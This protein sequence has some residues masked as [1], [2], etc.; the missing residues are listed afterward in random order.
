MLPMVVME[1]SG[2]MAKAAPKNSSEQQTENSD[3]LW[4]LLADVRGDVAKQPAPATVRRMRA[5]L[6]AGMKRPV[7]IA[8]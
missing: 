7:K 3:W 4:Q 1:V 2:I 5:R 8:A 6:E